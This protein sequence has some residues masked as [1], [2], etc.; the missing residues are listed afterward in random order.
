[1]FQ[2]DRKNQLSTHRVVNVP[3]VLKKKKK[4]KEFNIEINVCLCEH[5]GHVVYLFMFRDGFFFVNDRL[6]T[7]ALYQS[8]KKL[9]VMISILTFF[10]SVL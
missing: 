1:M 7:A 2:T 10:F 3:V 8:K 9:K 5:L 4:K 6:H